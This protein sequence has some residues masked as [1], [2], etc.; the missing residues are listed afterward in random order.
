M[1]FKGKKGVFPALLFFCGALLPVAGNVQAAGVAVQPAGMD[2]KVEKTATIQ[3]NQNIVVVSGRMSLGWIHGDSNEL[4]YDPGTGRKISEL[5]WEIDNVYMLGIGGSLSPLSWLNFN[6]DIWF[7]VNDGDGEMNDYDWLLDSP[8]YTHWSNHPDTDL[9]T[10]LMFDI[11]AEMTFYE[12]MGTKFF[13]I[14]GFK[15]D[16]W[17]WESFGGDYVY[18]GVSGSFP[19]GQNVITYEQKFYTPYVGIGFKSNLSET[20][21]TFS[22]RIIGSTFVTAEDKDQ[23]HLR[24]LVFEEDFDSGNMFAVDLSGAY[25][26]TDQLSLLVSYHFQRYDEM[27]GETTITDLTTG[28]V[29]KVDGDAAGIDHSSGMLSLSA[30]YTF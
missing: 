1:I 16:N 7:R 10:G 2:K 20:P 12:V 8:E 19:D 30:V 23:H 28:A 21:I 13:G 14:A 15:Y 24:N 26:F 22:G 18:W 9:T 3:I 25:N 11:N 4:V 17:E 27:K 29:T 6:A 5:N